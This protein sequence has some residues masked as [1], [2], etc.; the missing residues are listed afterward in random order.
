MIHWLVVNAG[1]MTGPPWRFL[2]EAELARLANLRF[3]KR[4]REWLLGRFAAKRLLIEALREYRDLDMRDVTVGNDPDGAPYLAVN[5]VGRVPLSLSLSHRDDLAFCALGDRP[6]PSVGADVERVEPRAESFVHDFFTAREATLAYG[7]PPSTRD[8]LVTVVWSAKEAVLK[9][10]RL[11]LTVD[12]RHVEIRPGGGDLWGVW[13]PLAVDCTLPD[14]PPLRGWWKPWGSH[15][16]TLATTD[17]GA[18]Q[19]RPAH[20]S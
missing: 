12:T 18:R 19:S 7:A 4:R 10:L 13:R 20:G 2:S 11:G 3:S 16:L 17:G 5:G 14:V 15:V 6:G 1:E 9:A 8:L